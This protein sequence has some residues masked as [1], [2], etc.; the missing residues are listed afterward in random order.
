MKGKSRLLR[1]LKHFSCAFHCSF[2][3]SFWLIH[4]NLVYS[5]SFRQLAKQAPFILPALSIADVHILPAIKFED[6]T[7]FNDL[8]IHSFPS[9]H[10][11]PEVDVQGRE[12][13]PEMI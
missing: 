9:H 10:T 1:R 11:V 12:Q 2:L 3:Q 7:I 8:A 13:D 4:S 6:N 5:P